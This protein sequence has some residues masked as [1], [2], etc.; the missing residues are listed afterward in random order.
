MVNLQVVSRRGQPHVPLLTLAVHIQVPRQR[1]VDHA[2]RSREVESVPSLRYLTEEN[3]HFS[4]HEATN[5]TALVPELGEGDA[6]P[7]QLV[8]DVIPLWV[9]PIPDHGRY[10][11]IIVEH[12]DQLVSL[13]GR[14]PN[15]ITLSV[16]TKS[17][18]YLLQSEQPDR[19]GR[20]LGPEV[21]LPYPLDLMA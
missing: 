14:Q 9:P 20:S 18:C 19:I 1:V 3:I 10:I 17:C 2:S 4:V 13:R 15:H 6:L 11:R 16:A 12:R 8:L 7:Q 5:G 21:R